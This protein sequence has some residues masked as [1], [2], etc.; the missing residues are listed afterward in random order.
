MEKIAVELE[1][2]HAILIFFQQTM[3]GDRKIPAPLDGVV[4]GGVQKARPLH[5]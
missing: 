4:D 1:L 3:E 2:G 5:G